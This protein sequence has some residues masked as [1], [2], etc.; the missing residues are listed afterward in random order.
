MSRR[1]VDEQIPDLTAP[2]CLE[3]LNDRVNVPAG[4]EG[5][6]RL[7]DRPGLPDELAKAA[8]GQLRVNLV[9]QEGPCQ[10]WREA[11]GVLH[12]SVERGLAWT[13]SGSAR[14]PDLCAPCSR[15]PCSRA[16][17]WRGRWRR[18]R[19]RRRPGETDAGEPTPVPLPSP[20]P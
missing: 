2:D 10:Q 16:D 17:S 15:C 18:R 19:C 13:K 7:D 6:R 8:R 12:R 20:G 3:V 1:N 4:D 9:A 14:L 11:A 5:R